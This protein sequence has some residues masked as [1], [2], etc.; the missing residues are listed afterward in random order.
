MLFLGARGAGK[1]T[2]IK[3]LN[4][5]G[6]VE[7]GLNPRQIK[8]QWPNSKAAV[9]VFDV[10]PTG[11]AIESQLS[12]YKAA[13]NAIGGLFIH[14]ASKVDIADHGKLKKLRSAVPDLHT[15]IDGLR[16]AIYS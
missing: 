10:S 8:R 14:A 7:P 15:D 3:Q 11:P 6:L 9:Y 1:T 13:K 5:R 16:T 4:R 2:M 12:S